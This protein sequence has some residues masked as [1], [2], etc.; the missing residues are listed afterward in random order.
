MSESRQTASTVS[1]VYLAFATAAAAVAVVALVAGISSANDGSGAAEH[2][3]CNDQ[4][5]SWAAGQAPLTNGFNNEDIA[6][7]NAD[8]QRAAAEA[9]QRC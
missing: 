9:M 5:A 1:P 2:Q 4:V 6:R 8:I 7:R 3:S